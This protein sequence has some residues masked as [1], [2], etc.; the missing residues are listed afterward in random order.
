[1]PAQQNLEPS[2][3]GPYPVIVTTLTAIEIVGV[4][5][6]I[7]HSHLKMDTTSRKKGEK[8]RVMQNCHLPLKVNFIHKTQ[9]LMLGILKDI[10]YTWPTENVKVWDWELSKGSCIFYPW[11]ATRKIMRILQNAFP[12]FVIFDLC[13]PLRGI[14]SRLTKKMRIDHF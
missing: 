14:Q 2:R 12:A 7:R 10:F 9:T 13:D 6:Y 1:M 8:W 4:K 3:K 5:A 11:S